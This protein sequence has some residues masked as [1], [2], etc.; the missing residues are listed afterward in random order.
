MKYKMQ[1]QY[2][3]IKT[4]RT[5]TIVQPSMSVNE[6]EAAVSAF[7]KSVE[8]GDN[9]ISNIVVQSDKFVNQVPAQ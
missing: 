5:Y 9:A 7:L 2:V 6:V 3:E 4:N 8:A 1:L